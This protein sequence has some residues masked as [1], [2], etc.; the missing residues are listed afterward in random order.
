MRDFFNR[1]Q[2]QLAERSEQGVHS[3]ASCGLYQSAQH[4]RMTAHGAGKKG[5]MVIGEAPTEADDKAGKPWQG[6]D[7]QLLRKTYR[8]FGV[9]LDQDCVSIYA[10]GCKP[11]KSVT[12]YEVACC[13]RKV[14]Q[15]IQ[16][17]KPRVVILHGTHAINS[18]V[19]FQVKDKQE[20]T[21]TWRGWTIPDRE[22]CAWL[23]PTFPPF[24]I[25]QQEEANEVEVLWKQDLKKAFS[26]IDE[27]LPMFQDEEEAVQI[28][29]NEELA[30]HTLRKILKD[31]PSMLSFDIETTGLKPYNTE[32][33]RMACI[34]F[35]DVDK[36]QTYV[37]PAPEEPKT[38]RLMK[39]VLEHP[40][41]GK[42]A[43]NMK[44]EDS[45]MKVLYD[46]DVAPWLFDTML[47]AHILDNRP[48]I[49]GLKF[50]AYAQFGLLGYEDTIS[51]YLKSEDSNSTNKVLDA[52]QDE[53]LRRKLML[54]CGIDAL[55]TGRLAAKQMKE[56]CML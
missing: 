44:Y 20:I 40:K 21:T 37:I 11:D 45:W 42:I 43:T 49:T 54:Y 12:G 19:R 2:V 10:I 47:A 28:I 52:M 32:I 41:I 23:C 7:G 5:I 27:P 4:P 15:A 50:Q 18:V 24:F 1:Q 46:I 22:H 25:A 14:L 26:L 51:P 13:R 29:D 16:Q 35:S 9:D 38:M 33:H 55:T 3:C 8:Q 56:L 39:R 6:R 34:A 17:H 53:T 30:Q 48:A 36:E 31:V